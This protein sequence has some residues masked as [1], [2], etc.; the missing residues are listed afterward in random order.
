M[1]WFASRDA[2]YGVIAMI[3]G[4][5]CVRAGLRYSVT[6][7]RTPSRIATFWSHTI[8]TGSSLSS[9][10]WANA[11][12]THTMRQSSVANRFGIVPCDFISSRT[13]KRAARLAE[14]GK[15]VEGSLGM[16]ARA[17]DLGDADA[18]L[19]TAGVRAGRTEQG[20]E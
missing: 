13:P 1:P 19:A 9:V 6:L 4:T 12:G 2:M 17:P 18:A 7:S 8:W 3:A 16:A 20:V 5:R 10:G 15:L 11:A 14:A